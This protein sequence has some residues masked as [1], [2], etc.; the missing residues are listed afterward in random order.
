MTR[1]TA[2]GDGTMT[3]KEKIAQAAALLI[4]AADLLTEADVAAPRMTK[5]KPE[6]ARAR[7]N[8]MLMVTLKSFLGEFNGHMVK[9]AFARMHGEQFSP[10]GFG[11]RMAVLAT[12][13]LV[14]RV[15]HTHYRMTEKGRAA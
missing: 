12:R 13:G 9:E 15:D 8:R 6:T 3:S 14:E 10:S 7:G 11:S 1:E 2:E 4:Q 5:Q